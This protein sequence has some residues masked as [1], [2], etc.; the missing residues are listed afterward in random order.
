M[1]RFIFIAI[2]LLIS[3]FLFSQQTYDL[4]FVQTKVIKLSGKTTEKAGHLTFDGVDQLS[5]VYSNPE[6]EYFN[7]E[8][9]LVKV[10]LDGKKAELNADKVKMVRLQR[11]T[12][13]NCLSGNWEQAATDNN[14]ESSV[15]E[16]GA[17]KVVT[18]T[19]KKAAPRGYSKII[20]TYRKSDNLT[21]EMVLEEFNGNITTI[22]LS[23]I[24]NKK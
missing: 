15:V 6:G 12:L 22:K 10:N 18:L 16:K 8:G 4:D 11:S 9:S 13:L 17:N 1:K 7:I 2:S 21:L 5:M 23:N 20:I 24:V 19:A 3:S 14:A